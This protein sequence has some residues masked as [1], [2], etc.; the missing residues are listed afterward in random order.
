[1]LE[2]F[3]GIFQ[4]LLSDPELSYAFLTIFMWDAIRVTPDGLLWSF[5]GVMYITVSSY[6]YY[7]VLQIAPFIWIGRVIKDF[8][9][10]ILDRVIIIPR[11]S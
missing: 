5:I 2:N 4:N 9:M 10:S 8:T 7:Y 3:L 6:V 1:M 11:V